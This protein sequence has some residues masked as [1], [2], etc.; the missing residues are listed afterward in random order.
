MAVGLAT[1][2]QQFAKAQGL[3][4][5]LQRQEKILKTELRELEAEE[6]IL[7][8]VCN[9]LRTLIDQ[10][11][12]NSVSAVERLQNEGLQRVFTDQDISVKSEVEVC[13][14]KVSVALTTVQKQANGLVIEGVSND[15][16]GGSVVTVQSV[17][18]RITVM[19]R[20]G[21]RPVMFLD[22]ALPAFDDTYVY[23]MGAFLRSLCERLGID[24]LMVTHIAA[25]SDSANRAYRISNKAG[26]ATLR[27]VTVEPR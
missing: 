25:L 20:R 26:E 4:E 18:L 13:R 16:F 12:S 24:L 9:L 21:M 5:S 27:S 7:D 8:L 22:E 14:G 23:N 11:V 1:A 6:E 10:E 19:F 17:I 15:A 3:R 2:Q